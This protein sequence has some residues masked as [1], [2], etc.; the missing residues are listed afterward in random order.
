MRKIACAVAGAVLTGVALL[1]AAPA[2]A[3]PQGEQGVT[4]VGAP[5][6]SC[7][8]SF[9]AATTFFGVLHT[10]MTNTCTDVQR[11]RSSFAPAFTPDPTCYELSPGQQAVYNKQVFPYSSAANYK[12]LGLVTC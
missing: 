10:E 6:P 3:A 7:V 2:G 8:Q 9:Y 1:G 5:A 4:T 12:F 11:V